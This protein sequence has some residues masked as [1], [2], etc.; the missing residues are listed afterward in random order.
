LV[1]PKVTLDTEDINCIELNLSWET[2]ENILLIR[3]VEG[4][5]ESIYIYYED[6]KEKLQKWYRIEDE[7]PDWITNNLLLFTE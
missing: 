1:Y 4:R 2:E 7:L 6:F 3:I 5:H